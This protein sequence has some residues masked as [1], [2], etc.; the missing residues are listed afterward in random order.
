MFNWNLLVPI[1]HGIVSILTIILWINPDNRVLL[2]TVLTTEGILCTFVRGFGMISCIFLNILLESLFAWGRFKNHGYRK[3]I[4]IYTAY[5]I[6]LLNLI[7][8]GWDIYFFTVGF[9]LFTLGSSLFVY[10]LVK[11][12][13]TYY[14]PQMTRLNEILAG[15][16]ELPGYGEQINLK[17]YGFTERQLKCAACAIRDNMTY[18]KIAEEMGISLSIVKRE[19]AI[20]CKQFAVKNRDELYLLFIQ[21]KVDYGL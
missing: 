10:T 19:M 21:Y 4:L 20:V 12:K 18:P 5:L 16:N 13:L 7:R 9:S 8:E 6:I 3:V 17:D 14:V 15:E 2:V 1:I 11:E